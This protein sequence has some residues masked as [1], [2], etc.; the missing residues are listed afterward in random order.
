IVVVAPDDGGIDLPGGKPGKFDD[1]T[2]NIINNDNIFTVSYQS[3]TVY[4]SSN[5]ET[6]VSE[7]FD[8]SSNNAIIKTIKVGSQPSDIDINTNSNKIYVANAGNNTV[9]V[10]DGFTDNVINNNITVGNG[11]SDIKINEKTNKIYVAN[12][13]SNTVSVIDG[14]TDNVIN[15][16]ITVGN[17]PSDVA[18]NENTNM[19]Y[20]TNNS[21]NSVS[22]ID[23]F[24]DN[25]VAGLKFSITP[26]YAG[27]IIC[28]EKEYPLNVYIYVIPGTE[29]KAET[30]KAFEFRGWLENLNKDSSIPI[31]PSE[32]S[33]S[34]YNSF[35]KFFNVYH[36]DPT[37]KV[38][39]YGTFTANFKEL[40]PP[41]PPEYW[42]AL[43]GV[44]V[45]SIVGS[46]FIPGIIKWGK[47]KLQMKEFRR[48]RSNIEPSNKVTQQ[49]TENNIDIESITDAYAEGKI[50][51]LQYKLLK[52]KIEI[53]TAEN[54]KIKNKFTSQNQIDKKT[55]V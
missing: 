48:L 20:V 41:F 14:F 23:G 51:E 27:Q 35:L 47:T 17:G 5:N 29:C 8:N 46:W 36:E 22:V 28:G 50:N 32:N 10:I 19:I 7:G 6:A 31:H 40:P 24:T 43:F 25:I 30:K 49:S 13:G 2:Y 33:N 12:A 26:A 9:S 42:L 1:S 11:P 34:F 54:N 37:F 44:I 53:N 45:S 18:I 55:P 15:N 38:T 21:S 39:K 4:N 52:E 3:S 16:N